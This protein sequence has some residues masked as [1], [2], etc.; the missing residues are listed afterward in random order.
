MT[1]FTIFWVLLP[2]VLGF[3]SYL[4]PA[5]ARWSSLLTAIASTAYALRCIL[6]PQAIEIQLLDSFGVTLLSDQLG[7]Y[8]ILTNALVTAAVTLYCWSSDRQAYFYTPMMILHGSINAVFIAAD[9]ITI[10]VGLEVISIAAFL[11][12][13][14]A[15]SDRS[16]WV[17]LRYLLVSNAA[18]LFYLM[19]AGLVYQS[20]ESFALAG[21]QNAPTE[22]IALLLV[23]L[24]A[25]GGIFVSGLW[26]P[27]THG[28]VA[29]PVSALLSGS[30]IKAG[31]LPLVRFSL[32]FAD[33]APILQWLSVCTAILGVSLAIFQTDTKRVL[34]LSTLSQM[35]F[36]LI[37]PLNAGIY[38][39]THGV[40]KAALFLMAG[41]LPSRDFR[42]FLGFLPPLAKSI[43]RPNCPWVDSDRWVRLGQLDNG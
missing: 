40:A 36:I 1:Q 25:K 43:V 3:T 4:L 7:G 16:L 10:Y 42:R 33:I 39:L 20:N 14:D 35:G 17:G 18:M 23:G 30:V 27:F 5:I 6:Y 13:V 26:L 34:A 24:L 8:F 29:A 32:M 37:N 38:A 15:Q 19:G 12:M 21:I 9:L 31:V 28:E 41:Q 11:L 2:L 22:A